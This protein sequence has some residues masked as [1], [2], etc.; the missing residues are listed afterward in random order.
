MSDSKTPSQFRK[1]FD[2]TFEKPALPILVLLLTAL[3]LFFAKAFWLALICLFA[4]LPYYRR[5]FRI[6]E[7]R[8]QSVAAETKKVDAQLNLELL[9]VQKL[10]FARLGN[11]DL[12]LQTRVA[13]LLVDAA[14]HLGYPY[15][16]GR[17]VYP[18]D[19]VLKWN[20]EGLALV[21]QA[22]TL[23]ESHEVR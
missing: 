23:I 20:Q 8:R 15:L 21:A 9:E 18:V 13:D 1:A 19:Y 11:A 4:A 2:A 17:T 3:L 14:R 5:L 16:G 6:N 12:Q 22:R 7:A 10:A